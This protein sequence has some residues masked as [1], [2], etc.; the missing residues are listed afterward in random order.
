M[1]ISEL[2]LGTSFW[3]AVAAIV[4][5]TLFSFW[6]TLRWLEQQWRTEPDYS[7]G[8]LMIPLALIVLKMRWEWFPGV[9]SKVDW[10]G[11]SLIGLAILMRVVG[12]LAYMD[13]MD[14]WALVPMIAGIVWLLFG[15][16]ALRWAAPAIALLIMLVPLPYRAESLLSWKLQG[17]ATSLSTIMLRILGQPAIAEGHTIWIGE[18]RMMVED[19]C[20]GMRIF[21]GMFALAF[22]WCATVRRSWMD[23]VVIL[24]AALPAAVLVNSL[25]IT[26]TSILYGYFPS[27]SARHMIH[28]ISGYLM[29]V[30][31]AVLLWGV[32]AYWENLY[33]P[34]VV[35]NPAERLSQ[36]TAAN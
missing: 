3:V 6:P 21:V 33:R 35:V 20:S 25:R 18:T 10:R 5:A 32:K 12:R 15:W 31:G 27:S 22:F 29:I 28:D 2:N 16:P 23:R 17:V 11:L 30:V 4:I 9:R 26:A 34:L 14:G 8:Y 7:H 19:A 36:P 24:I 13:F 1:P